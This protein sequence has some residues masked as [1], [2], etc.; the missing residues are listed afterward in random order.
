MRRTAVIVRGGL[1]VAT[2]VLVAILVVGFIGQSESPPSPIASPENTE[3]GADRETVVPRTAPPRSFLGANGIL[4][5]PREETA[6]APAP[7]PHSLTHPADVRNEPIAVSHSDIVPASG[8]MPLAPEVPA[9]APPTRPLPP[10][11]AV[12]TAG[13]VVPSTPVINVAAAVPGAPT[14]PVVPIPTMAAV[15]DAPLPIAPSFPP[16]STPDGPVIP[17]SVP[18]ASG[19]PIAPPLAIAPVAATSQSAAA[20]AAP[21]AST[22]PASAAAAPALPTSIQSQEKS[23]TPLAVPQVAPTPEPLANLNALVQ[24]PP[25]SVPLPAGFGLGADGTPLNDY[26]RYGLR[27]ESADKN[28]S[29]F[30]GGRFQFDVVNYLASTGMRENIP[31]N[32]PLEDGVSFRRVRLDMGGTLYKNIEYYAQVDFFNG[33]V[34][35]IAENRLSNVTVP[36][37]MWV[38]FSDLPWVGNIRVGNQKPLYS[39]EHLTSSRFLNFLER[40]LGFDA[41]AENFNNGFAPGIT[42][43]R[44]FF[45]RLA[46]AGIGVFKNTRGA[47]GWNVGR[48]ETEVSGRVTGLPVF[49]E[50][51]KYLVHVGVGAADRDLDDDQVRM[52]ARLDARNSPSA[53]GPL[54][55]D[56]G[57]FFGTRQQVLIPELAVV[58]GPWTFQSEYYASWVQRAFTVGPTG[59]PAESQGTIYMQ[60][61]YGEVLYFLTGEHREYDRNNGVFT[62]VVPKRPLAWSRCGFTGC[63]AWQVA[64][65]YS[66]LDLNDK[67]ISGG[68]IH[69]MTLGLNWFLNPNM[70]VQWNYFLAHRNVVDPAGDGFIQ[71]FG[72]R[73]AIDF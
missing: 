8:T 63:G 40:S 2:M 73:L 9:T 53:F 61:V 44:T 33:F 66:Y 62:R 48:N 55:A 36:T 39:F 22:P 65:R 64:A 19:G 12:A 24:Q 3:A 25:D 58:A 34:T 31:G 56:T 72:T 30:V 46:T 59:R 14:A 57:L 4:V 37:D 45:N 50:D 35:S 49:Y 70:K 26:W 27:F 71:G 20:T 67:A 16:T 15:P 11:A 52:R 60:S 13:P 6:M 42:F 1:C 29:L 43:R 32:V 38:Q 54:I 28:F 23:S 47:F 51:G 17:A 41:F 68:R 10:S 7:L 18:T 5:R 21:A 69:D